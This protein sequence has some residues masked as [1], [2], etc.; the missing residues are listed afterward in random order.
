MLTQLEQIRTEGLAELS[1]IHDE[2]ALEAFRVA[3]L[4]KKGKLTAVAAGMRDVPPDQKPAV[5]AMLNEVRT[6]LSAGIDAKQ[7]ALKSA[8]DAEA[9]KGIDVTLP[10]RPSSA[11]AL[12]PL[13][14]L[15]DRAVQALRRM[16]FALADGPEIETE[17]HCFDALNT[18]ADHPARNE[19]D[20]F[21]LPDGRLLRTHTSTVQIRTMESVKALPVRIIAP[22]AAYRR[23]EIDATHLSVF[24]QLEG[25]YVDRNVSLSDLKG[26]LEFFFQEIFGAG[27]QVRF[28]PHFFPFTEPSFEI[29]IKLE[30]KG[31]DARWIEIAGCGMVDPA[32]FESVCKTRGDRLFDPDQITGFAFGLGLDR[33][34]MILHGI[35]DIRHLIEN[36]V[37][38]LAQF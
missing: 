19:K 35:T 27:T 5:G 30:A 17:W 34:A 6:A 31:Q 7:T 15:R 8:K 12:H 22:G 4:G 20:T 13:T 38:F 26:T 14:R 1:A 28:R 21:F 2:T 23:D 16:G 11:G 18:P 29:D 32:V 33:L 37:R 24:N 10:G 9:V 36:D 3:Y 25:L